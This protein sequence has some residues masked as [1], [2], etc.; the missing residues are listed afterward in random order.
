VNVG[1]YYLQIIFL[2]K[3]DYQA[4]TDQGECSLLF[5]CFGS[6]YLTYCEQSRR[7][8]LHYGTSS[9]RKSLC[10][11][12]AGICLVRQRSAILSVVMMLG[13]HLILDPPPPRYS[14]LLFRL[15]ILI[16]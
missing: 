12:M 14:L 8:I 6:I 10:L 13:E 16:R 2:S 5:L 9:A 1:L 4:H 3:F 11:K 7:I 15:P